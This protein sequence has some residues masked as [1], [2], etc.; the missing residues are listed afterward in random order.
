MEKQSQKET[1]P[2]KTQED[3]HIRAQHDLA[4]ALN[5]TT[6]LTEGLQL[7]L[8][9]AL[10]VSGMDCGGIYLV[11][12][13]VHTLE[14]LTHKGLGP[15]FI[16]SASLYSGDSAQYKLV[17]K[18]LPIYCTYRELNVPKNRV[19]TREGLRSFALIPMR[20]EKR[21]ICCLNLASHTADEIDKSTRDVLE[22]ITA[23]VAGAIARLKAETDLRESEDKY[24]ELFELESDA[25]FLI[26]N[27][28]GR[29][30]EANSAAS[31]M[32]GYTH[33]ELLT[34]KNT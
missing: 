22:T 32:Y 17:M 27:D 24:R 14:L 16:R 8:K 23:Q 26:Q 4:L 33:R 6:N 2:A 11:N 3:P 34:M 15:G 13:T 31:A 1:I 28:T 19:R 5:A 10:E 30:L 7:C 25:I 29:I 21:I 18:G 12:E 20:F 9:T